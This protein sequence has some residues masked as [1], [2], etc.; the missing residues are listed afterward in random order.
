MKAPGPRGPSQFNFYLIPM[1]IFF[2][3]GK[4][5]RH[6]VYDWTVVMLWF[7][8]VG[9][10]TLSCN[11]HPPSREPSPSSRAETLPLCPPTPVAFQPLAPVPL[12][13]SVNLTLLGTSQE[14]N[15]TVFVFW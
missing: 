9:T 8:A 7:G 5:A 14:W 12:S 2:S 1:F 6:E 13:V 3:C 15:R 11:H 10:L 4:C